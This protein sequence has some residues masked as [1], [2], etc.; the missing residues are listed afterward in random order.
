MD[1]QA[2]AAG[3]GRGEAVGR[4]S[5]GSLGDVFESMLDATAEAFAAVDSEGLI[6]AW[7]RAASET[8]GWS[9]VEALG[10]PLPELIVPARHR[11]AHLRDLRRVLE[12]GEASLL[13]RGVEFEALHRDGHEFPLELSL[14]LSRVEAGGPAG[15][16]A[17][18]RC[19]SERCATERLHVERKRFKHSFEAAP[20]GMA[21]VAPDGEFLAVNPKL[22]GLL[23]RSSED[24]R[25]TGFQPLTHPEDLDEDLAQLRATLGGEIDGYQMEKRYLRPDGSVVWAE[26]HV[27]LIRDGDGE[28]LHFVSQLV[29]IS[30]RKRAE[31]ELRS[32]HRELQELD[33][34]DSV[35]GLA[36][37]EAF[38]AGLGRALTEAERTGAP[39]SLVLLDLGSRADALPLRRVGELLGDWLRQS[40]LAARA[41]ERRVALLLPG[42]AREEAAAT[43]ERLRGALVE[44]ELDLE[45][46]AGVASHPA[47]GR[48]PELLIRRAQH[49]LDA[50]RRRRAAPG[51]EDRGQLRGPLRERVQSLL[52]LARGHL[53]MDVAFL[54]EFTDGKEIFRAVEGDVPGLTEGSER[55]LEATY[56]HRMADGRIANV[57]RDVQSESELRDLEVTREAEL[58]SYIGVPME[59]P[60]RDF[61][62]ALCVGGH[63]SR[64]ELGERELELMRF[65]AELVAEAIA[66][67]QDEQAVR[68]GERIDSGIRALLSALTARD[69]YTGEHCDAVVALA[70]KVARRLGLPPHAVEEIGR[71][72]LLHDIGKVGIPDSILQK[73]G[74]LT[75]LE[76][77]LVRQHPVIGERIV[78][79]VDA[80][81]PLGRAV[82][83][84]HERFDGSGYPDGLAGTRIPLASRITLACDAYHAMISDRPYRAAMQAEEA[85]EE[86]RR[87][88]GSQFDP[89]V[90]A[91]LI[92]VVTADDPAQVVGEEVG[93]LG[94]AA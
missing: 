80:L 51:G 61:Y 21:L 77:D 86:L 10:R 5:P 75:E 47:A 52:G 48:A 91:M 39:L 60:E 11:D 56:C 42:T 72:A 66:R 53:G 34:T 64:P 17:F 71:V 92:E 57:V 22:C 31:G 73:Q 78:V 85:V 69:H 29:D 83:S 30:E 50:D 90:A 15:A 2:S 9:R 84:E 36:S 67:D 58:G 46:S 41:G 35:S 20:I 62:G 89:R 19:T 59:L 37:Y 81:A 55:E 87:G 76:W 38:E 93:A 18:V 1:D 82:R 79:A 14:S 49:D 3:N 12:G 65:L 74:P 16:C 6:V 70:T 40:D 33:R 88:A 26:L 43:V 25:A 23:G 8:F 32:Y 13:G 45:L 27:S 28:P 68:R 4:S 7:N 94:S 24:L 44:H 63:D 54:G